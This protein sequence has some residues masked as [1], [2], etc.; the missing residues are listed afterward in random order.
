M[1]D[2]GPRLQAATTTVTAAGG[3]GLQTDEASAAA[4]AQSAN[5]QPAAPPAYATI[6]ALIKDQHADVREW[7][8]Y[9]L[10]VGVDKIYLIDTGSQVSTATVL[11]DYIAAGLVDFS[12]DA[13]IPASPGTHGPQLTAYSRCLEKGRQRYCAREGVWEGAS[14][15]E[16]KDVRPVRLSLSRT[17]GACWGVT[18]RRDTYAHPLQI[19]MA[20]ATVSV[21][22]ST[23]P[24]RM[25]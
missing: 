19:M 24:S 25:P 8:A 17:G 12:Y 9:H 11:Q 2:W 20:L 15:F 1:Y 13:H 4:A 22:L 5:A 6:C 14:R 23:R 16:W 18:R 10:A 21:G 7:V 3:S